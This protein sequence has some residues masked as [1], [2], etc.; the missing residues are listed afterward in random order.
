MHISNQIIFMLFSGLFST[1][2]TADCFIKAGKWFAIDPDYL[3]AIAWQE[4]RNNPSTINYNRSSN[5]KVISADYGVMQI[6]D[7]TLRTFQKEY[8]SLTSKK[9]LEDLCLNIHLGAML[10]RR[11]F[12]RYGISW[13]AV[14]I[15]NTGIKNRRESAINRHQYSILIDRHYKNIKSG[16]IP[17]QPFDN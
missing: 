11:N 16:R 5:G 7:A 12:D 15:Y 6:N 2:T 9:L 10:L 4:S 14:G 3:R 17:R 13:L 8:P 1:S